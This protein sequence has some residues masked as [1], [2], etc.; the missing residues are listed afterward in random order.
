[1]RRALLLPLL[2]LLALLPAC[3]TTGSPGGSGGGT[4]RPAP[5]RAADARGVLEAVFRYQFE[6]NDSGLQDRAAAYCLCVP[7]REGRRGG[8]RDPEPGLLELFRGRKPPVLPC[9]GCRVEG[10]RVVETREGRPALTFRVAALRWLGRD[11]AEVEGGYGEGNLSASGQRFRVVR[12]E[13]GWKVADVRGLWV[14]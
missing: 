8:E 14:S 7:D 3:A 13:A 12:G 4:P 5:D 11:E 9:S 10:G 1:M 6:H 2:L